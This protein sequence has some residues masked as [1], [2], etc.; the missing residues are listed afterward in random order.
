MVVL[1]GV[2]LLFILLLMFNSHVHL[3]LEQQCTPA[4]VSGCLQSR[5]LR[6]SDVLGVKVAESHAEVTEV[7]PAADSAAPLAL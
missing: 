5:F 1:R 6:N 4:H 7:A 2:L 3:I